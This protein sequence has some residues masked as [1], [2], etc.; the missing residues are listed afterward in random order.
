VI[1][2][3][4][5]RLYSEHFPDRPSLG[6]SKGWLTGTWCI[7]AAYKNPN[8]LYGAYPRGYLERVHCMF[9]EAT[10]VLHLFSGGLDIATATSEAARFCKRLARV[11]L[12]DAKGP[13]A[14]RFPTTQCEADALPAS[15]VEAFDL[16]LAD[17]PYSVED[18][19]R[20]DH[21][22]PNCAA[23]LR[24]LWRAARP[25]A[26]LVWLD[27]RWPMHEKRDWETWGHI[28]LVRS[29]NHRVRLVSFFRRSP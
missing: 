13:E 3:T 17:P 25:G 18:A 4:C 14:G 11:E 6:A 20:Y 2:K 10:S 12:V 5:A 29:T 24:G 8:Q 27:T 1:A 15:W 22:M 28:G 23:V 19:A 9:P 21:P 16:I 26:T 7:G